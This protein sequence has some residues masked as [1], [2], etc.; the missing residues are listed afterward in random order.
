MPKENPAVLVE[1]L[2]KQKNPWTRFSEIREFA[3]N[4]WESIP[5]DWL[6]TYFRW[7][8]VYTQGNGE[9]VLGGTGGEGKTAPWFMV[10][11]RIP[12]GLLTSVQARVI[13]DLSKRYGRGLADITTRHNIQLHWIRIEDLPD[14]L[15]AVQ[16]C[17]L[18]TLA[19]CGDDARNITGCSLAGLDANE[20]C[21]ASPL[22]LQAAEMLVG[23]K[24][25]Y[26]LPRKY[27]VSI[28]GCRVWCCFPEINDLA[29]TATRR[30][31]EVGFSL[32]VGGGLA[33]TPHFA[34][35]LDAFVR[36]E[37]V[38]P[39]VRATTELFR[40]TDELRESRKRARLKFLF[41]KA[42]WTEERF[43]D[44]LHARLPFVLDPA[45]P[46]H[47]PTSPYRD[48]VGV[49]PQKQPGLSYVGICVP[50][51][52]ISPEQLRAAANLAD[53]FGGGRLRTT[54]TQN[55]VVVDVPSTQTDSVVRSLAEWGLAT[56]ASPFA[57]GM[58]PCTGSEFC[59]L[60]L[61]ETKTFAQA[62]TLELEERLPDYDQPLRISVTGCPNGCAQHAVADIGLEGCKIRVDGRFE[63]GFSFRV[64]GSVGAQRVFG[65]TTG[66]RCL[67]EE[68]PD[69]LEG[70]LRSYLRDQAAN[71]SFRSF[72]QT[73]EPTRVGELLSLA[74]SQ[75]QAVEDV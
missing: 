37:Q 68:V 55:L 70:L 48:H 69:V 9:G 8:G 36:S 67:A 13:A 32:R 14:V 16:D 21:D 18:T 15:E 51:G 23:A 19:A 75:R 31:K 50:R 6:R 56:F 71:Q 47:E 64:G 10:R 34:R 46:E 22:V 4:G 5:E 3:S 66:F 62:L 27:K 39:V 58:L 43:L 44:E 30:G 49:Y 60:A 24:E 25:F 74:L 54:T 11:V 45:E 1:R 41:L 61:T 2:K 73:T 63:D 72:L 7:W 59:K 53:R 17:G 28:T 52:R 57:R 42:G 65:Q 12:S 40:D 20:L 26:N 29:F 35:R 33:S 38:L